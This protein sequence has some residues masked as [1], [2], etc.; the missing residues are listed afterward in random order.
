MN[1]PPAAILNVM[2]HAFGDTTLNRLEFQKYKM[3]QFLTGDIWK[4]VNK[5]FV[6]RQIKIACIAYVTL[7]N[8]QL[9][10]GDTLICNASDDKIKFGST[11]AKVIDLYFKKGVTILSNQNLHAKLL[12]TNSFI[13]IGSANL[14]NISADTLVESA[15]VTDNDILLSQ[16]KSFCHNLMG[17]KETVT[18][19]R[20]HIDRLLKI[21][22]V[23]RSF[24]PT[25]KSKTREKKFGNRFWYLPLG[26]LS[27]RTYQKVKDKIE[28][29]KKK[30]IDK[31]EFTEDDVGSIY[32]RSKTNFSSLA[33]E[34]DQVMMNWHNKNKTRNNIFPFATILSIDKENDETIFIYDNTKSREKLSLTKFISLTKD[35]ELE[36]SLDKPRTKELTFGD[37]I[38][39]KALWK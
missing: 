14:S 21:K 25:T 27:D 24:K 32:F 1:S 28:T 8:L 35:L 38:K 20:K 4:E 26:E 12:L 5:L 6:K 9:T 7:D 23:R 10:K 29:S 34:G 17:E 3:E 37:A 33:Q 31:A 22:V 19:T 2:R 16:V 30:V 18:L 11:T 39:L 36:K 13:V 15:V